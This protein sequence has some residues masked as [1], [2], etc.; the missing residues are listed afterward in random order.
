MP[1]DKVTKAKEINLWW[2]MYW[3]KKTPI[4][5]KPKKVR[6]PFKF[7]VGD[8]VRI[9]HLRN[10]FSREYDEKWSGEIFVISER[11]LRGGLPIYRLKDHLNE[12]IKGTFYQQELQKVNVREDDEFKVE[13][14]LQTKGRGRNKQYLVKWL[15]W[16][17]KFNSWVYANEVKA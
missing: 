6:K 14:I 7:K 15:H 3:P 13:K 9:S 2:S 4:V 1:P 12:E 17:S 11:Q 10:V 8:N 5:T 16:P